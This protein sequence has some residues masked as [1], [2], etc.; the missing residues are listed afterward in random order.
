[1]E[2]APSRAGGDLNVAL[3]GSAARIPTVPAECVSVRHLYPVR[4]PAATRDALRQ[5][6]QDRGVQ[7]QIHYP[8]PL[9]RQ[10]AYASLFQGQRFP[11]AEEAAEEL[12]SLPI[13][14]QMTDE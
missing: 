2:P 5:K 11:A 12:I 6:L 1:M 9:H 8:V 3:R 14:P 13:Y 10:K 4:V 7:T